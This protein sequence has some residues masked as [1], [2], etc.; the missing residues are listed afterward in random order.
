MIHEVI[1]NIFTYIRSWF[2]AIEEEICLNSDTN[3]SKFLGVPLGKLETYR[4]TCRTWEE[5][6]KPC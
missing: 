5:T 3:F 2:E 4:E 1:Q 6:G